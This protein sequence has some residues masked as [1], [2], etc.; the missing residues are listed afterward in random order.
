M[1]STGRITTE[2]I[3]RIR[4]GAPGGLE[5]FV[6]VF[7]P[8]ILVFIN[9]KLGDK[10]RGKIEPEDVLQDFFA[11]LVENREGFLDKVE[12]RGVHRTVYRLIENHIKDLYER[13]FQTKKR[14][15]HLEVREGVGATSSRS[16]FSFS[17]V[18]GET[19]SFSRRIETHDEYQSLQKIL[20]RLD[21]ESKRLFVL[22]FV[23]ECTNQEVAEE[24]NTSVSSVK[25]LTTDLVLKIQ[26]A[27][28]GI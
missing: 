6:R 4:N 14:D 19:A 13:H 5:D 15:S 26:K 18:A 28:K 16:G 8:K 22:K 12:A 11:S 1:D 25:R 27:R 21:E 9:Y 2:I 20:T 3:D 10:L 23:E 24:L 7:G 17:Q